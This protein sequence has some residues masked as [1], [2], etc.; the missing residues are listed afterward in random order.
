MMAMITRLSDS[1]FN[2]RQDVML[3][4]CFCPSCPAR[5]ETQT[6]M[7]FLKY[8]FSLAPLSLTSG[9][10]IK[11]RKLAFCPV[12]PLGFVLVYQ[13]DMAYGTLIYHLGSTQRASW[14]QTLRRQEEQIPELPL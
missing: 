5:M 14:S 7:E 2:P 13:M 11:K 4:V 10:A 8:F 12:I 6:L 3:G 1:Q 9:G